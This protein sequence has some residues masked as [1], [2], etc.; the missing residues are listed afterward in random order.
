[1]ILLY[2]NACCLYV[3]MIDIYSHGVK[4]IKNEIQKI[5]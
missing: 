5:Q 3:I 2:E 4:G 1:M